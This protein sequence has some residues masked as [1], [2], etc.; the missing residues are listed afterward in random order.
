MGS[1]LTETAS[2]TQSR[3]PADELMGD[4]LT[5]WPDG[6]DNAPVHNALSIFHSHLVSLLGSTCWEHECLSLKR[7]V[8][9]TKCRASTGALRSRH[10][11]WI[12]LQSSLSAF[13][14]TRWASLEILFHRI[15]RYIAIRS[16]SLLRHLVHGLNK[17][18]ANFGDVACKGQNDPPSVTTVRI[19]EGRYLP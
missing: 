6:L 2:A 1:W 7:R 19:R 13:P 18:H 8:L 15:S 4:H 14:Q 3:V 12:P 10:L 16:R 11:F 5:L 17:V 9:T